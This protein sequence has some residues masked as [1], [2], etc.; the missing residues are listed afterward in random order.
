MWKYIGKK[1]TNEF[2]LS[3]HL[4]D[5]KDDKQYLKTLY[6]ISNNIKDNYK[7]YKIKKHNGKF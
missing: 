3:L 7:I 6:S 5:Y 1:E 4:F 2:L